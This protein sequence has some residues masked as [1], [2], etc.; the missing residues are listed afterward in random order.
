MS[1]AITLAVN[2]A[3]S[4]GIEGALAYAFT[5]LPTA[6][7]AS[8]LCNLLTNPLLNVLL[9]AV[10]RFF[11][12]AY[13]GALVALELAV[14]AG[15][16]SLYRMLTGMRPGRAALLSVA[17]NAVSYGVGAVFWRLTAGG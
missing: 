10:L 13:W 11:P 4:I 6:V 7:Y 15:E 5:R 17:L 2:L 12:A 1:A 9:F 8:A 3:L 14:I 16:A